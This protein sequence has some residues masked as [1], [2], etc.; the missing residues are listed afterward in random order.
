MNV[1]DSINFITTDLIK[2]FIKT[3]VNISLNNNLI[4][5]VF[6]FLICKLL[7]FK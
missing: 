4:I 1:A 6:N 3:F 2:K 7:K 5:M